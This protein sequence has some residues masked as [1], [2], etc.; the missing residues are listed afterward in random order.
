[1]VSTKK[2]IGDLTDLIKDELNVKDVIF[3][4]NISEFMNIELKPNFKEVGKN[5]WEKYKEVTRPNK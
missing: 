4:E 2:K 3:E 1:M 5:S